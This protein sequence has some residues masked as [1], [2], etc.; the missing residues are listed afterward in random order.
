MIGSWL[1]RAKPAPRKA[2]APTARVMR[3][4]AAGTGTPGQT[5]RSDSAR[6]KA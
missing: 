6:P 1:L 4:A 5:M 3:N 2:S